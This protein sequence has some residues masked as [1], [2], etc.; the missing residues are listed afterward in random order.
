MIQ[1]K[2]KRIKLR[3][4]GMKVLALYYGINEQTVRRA[5]KYESST[6]LAEQLRQ[7]AIEMNL[8]ANTRIRL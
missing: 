8:I 4:G 7:K 6:L 5:M 1:N 2:K 3:Y